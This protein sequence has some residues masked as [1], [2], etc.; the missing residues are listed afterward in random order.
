[1]ISNKKPKILNV[2]S[3]F[4]SVPFFFGDQF[5]Y[6]KEKGYEIHLICSPSKK[7]EKYANSQ[8]VNFKEFVILRKFSVFQD[9]KTVFAIYK[10]IKQNN[11][12]IVVGHTPK[13]ALI[14]MLSSYLARTNSRIYF[15]HGL[16]YETATG[17]KRRILILI[18][19]F[20]AS[21]ANKVVC[22]SPS[23][24][25]ASNKNK[26]NDTNKNIILGKGT[27][28]GIDIN[29]FNKR[30]GNGLLKKIFTVGF[31]GRLVK[32]KGII[33]LI[34]AWKILLKSETNI[35]LLLVG[36]FEERDA[37][38][39]EIVEFILNEET[40]TYT[41]LVDDTV[42]YYSQMDAYILPSYREG[43]PTS[44]LE[45][46]AME[47]PIITTK[48]TGCINAIIP[49]KTGI[50]T[51]LNPTNI[52]QAIKYFIDNK[53]LSKKYGENG[54]SFVVKNFKQDIVW[55]FIEEEIYK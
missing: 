45:A 23:V 17:I 42:P 11:F 55:Q 8:G 12:D 18:E 30:E 9:I 51:A 44:V 2:V 31:V 32:D 49:N 15:R 13:G 46:S 20:T 19:K 29:R 21:L 40:I 41:G 5:K 33:E 52:A 26:L 50:Y 25:N 14:A 43:F 22:V 53:E 6:F 3:V 48:V 7:L 34:E 10:Y 37:L 39:P 38:P 28:N 16:A 35:N 47:L 24:L 4:F 1:M 27:C 36:P 54:R